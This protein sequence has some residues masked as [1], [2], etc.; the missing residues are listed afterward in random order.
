MFNNCKPSPTNGV[1]I[2][3]KIDMLNK[4]IDRVTEGLKQKGQKV[5]INML[6]WL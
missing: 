3:F 4:H 2:N 5:E 1:N 6:T